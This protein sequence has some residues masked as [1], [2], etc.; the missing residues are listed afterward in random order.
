MTTD[1]AALLQLEKRDECGEVRGGGRSDPM[2]VGVTLGH[3]QLLRRNLGLIF[4]TFICS[5]VQALV[6]VCITQEVCVC[7]CVF[8]RARARVCV[9]VCVRVCVCVSVCVCVCVCLSVCLSVYHH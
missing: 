8:A 5:E 3:L 1:P 2:A 4:F 6:P 7:L 9:C